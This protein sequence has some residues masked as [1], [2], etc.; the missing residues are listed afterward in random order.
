MKIARY[1]HND[2][3]TYGVLDGDDLVALRTDPL[4]GGF[5]TTGRRVPLDE[6]RLLSPIIPRSKVVG[7]GK[8]YADH[9]AEM[10]SEVPA[11]PIMFFVPNT[12]VIGP[13]DPIVLPPWDD[14]VHHE[15]ELAV[16]ISR[17][18]KDVPIERAKEVI[19]GYTVG[20][21]VSARTAQ[22]GDTTWA[23]GKGFDT[24]CPL[25]PFLVIPESDAE[26]DPTNAAVRCYVD[27]ELRQDGNTKDMIFSIPELISY[28]T[29][30]C[31]LLPGD[32]I[33]TGTPAGVGPIEHGQ[34]VECEI[35]GIGELTNLVIR[36]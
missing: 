24:S 18:C 22:R 3:I 6:V 1:T 15:A 29:S 19:F 23:R 17:P 32:V 16:V 5:E 14:V 20:N 26:F 33:L 21:D 13:D 12:A 25:G 28:V 36:R 10:N 7:I 4:F 34:R 11:E 27:G 2:E 31:S 35:E 8:N 9:A 30:V